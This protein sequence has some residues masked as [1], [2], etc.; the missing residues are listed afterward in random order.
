MWRSSRFTV[1]GLLS[2][3][4]GAYLSFCPNTKERAAIRGREEARQDIRQGKLVILRWSGGFGDQ[5]RPQIDPDVRDRLQVKDEIG[6]RGCVRDE[7]WDRMRADNDVM[8][9]EIERRL[10]LLPPVEKK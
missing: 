5:F 7:G 8:L 4:V 9:I 2:L 3:G 1:L 10:R 6:G